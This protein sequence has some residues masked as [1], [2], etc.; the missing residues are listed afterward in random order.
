MVSYPDPGDAPSALL[1]LWAECDSAD[2]LWLL[3]EKITH[4]TNLTGL[5][6]VLQ[7]YLP[8]WS[9]AEEEIL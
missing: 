7:E 8:R 4:N 2:I 3:R 9:E 1:D 5:L 6:V